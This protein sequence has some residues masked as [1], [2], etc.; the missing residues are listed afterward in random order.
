MLLNWNK[1]KW[2]FPWAVEEIEKLS[3]KQLFL[4]DTFTVDKCLEE[5]M[6]YER[7]NMVIDCFPLTL[8]FHKLAE[9][10][11]KR[12]PGLFRILFSLLFFCV[13]IELYGQKW[14]NGTR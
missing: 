14:E 12:Q 10:E 1:T 7:L 11:C 13:V 4:Q 6:I 3:K 9:L 8:H 2:T 5:T